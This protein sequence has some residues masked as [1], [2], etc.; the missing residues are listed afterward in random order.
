MYATLCRFLADKSELRFGEKFNKNAFHR[1]L[2]IK[3]E[4]TFRRG[5]EGEERAAQHQAAVG[6]LRFLGELFLK[7]LIT[8]NVA[9]EIIQ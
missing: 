8:S 4:E 9:F 6:N 5:C 2:L 3:C 7:N 1:A